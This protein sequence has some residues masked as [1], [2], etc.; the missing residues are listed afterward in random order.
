MNNLRYVHW[1]EDGGKS[2]S[3]AGKSGIGLAIPKD[4]EP[5][6]AGTG[7][8]VN[9]RAYLEFLSYNN[10]FL[11]LKGLLTGLSVENAGDLWARSAAIRQLIMRSAVPEH[12]SR[13]ITAAYQ[14][15][16]AATTDG[17]NP[18]VTVQGTITVTATGDG[19][20]NLIEQYDP[21]VDISDPRQVVQYVQRCWGHLWAPRAIYYREKLSCPHLDVL[22]EVLVAKDPVQETAIA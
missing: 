12:M 11:D 8:W 1:L 21:Y 2:C 6:P 13:E 5:V 9:S 10:L 22:P 16:T 20:K 15:L 18:V 7:F 3:E 14:K 19:V 17:A 4:Q